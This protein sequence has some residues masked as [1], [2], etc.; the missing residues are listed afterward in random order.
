MPGVTD[1]FVHLKNDDMTRLRVLV[2]DDYPDAAETACVLLEL[3]GYECCFATCGL[4]GLRVAEDFQPNVA[5]LDI[6]LP[7]ISGFELAR[8]LRTRFSGRPLFLA[9]I[10]GWGQAEDRVKALAAGFD[11]HVVKPADLTKL[12]MIME[13]AAAGRLEITSSAS[14]P[15]PA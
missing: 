2:V 14:G 4:D 13:A 6:G 5:I 15:A 9:A 10:T 11:L 8:R 12:T 7:D 1:H 3:L